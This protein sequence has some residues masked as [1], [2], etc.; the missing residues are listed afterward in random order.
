MLALYYHSAT[1]CKIAT[2]GS[3]LGSTIAIICVSFYYNLGVFS[4]LTQPKHNYNFMDSFYIKPWMRCPPY[5]LGLLFGIYYREY[6]NEKKKGTNECLFSKL[7]LKIHST[8]YTKWILYIV[9]TGII[10]VFI[11]GPR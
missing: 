7:K 5:L 1:L 3:I 2:I 8:W 10:N 11:W 6:Y 4:Y 9:G